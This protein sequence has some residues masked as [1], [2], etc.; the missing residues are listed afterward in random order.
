M[1]VTLGDVGSGLSNPHPRFFPAVMVGNIAGDA[2][3]FM[4]RLVLS[5]RLSEVESEIGC[6][7]R[8]DMTRPGLRIDLDEIFMMKIEIKELSICSNVVGVVVR[9]EC[10]GVHEM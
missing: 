5:R 7:S 2:A 8:P 3:P 1:Q 10:V 4:L 6:G 9:W